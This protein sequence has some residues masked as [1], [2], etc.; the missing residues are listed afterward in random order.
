MNWTTD[1]LS[2][3][4]QYGN[5]Q[6]LEGC[7]I[8]ENTFESLFQDSTHPYATKIYINIFCYKSGTWLF[9]IIIVLYSQHERLQ[10]RCG[11]FWNG[12]TILTL[13]HIGIIQVWK[14]QI[15]ILKKLIGKIILNSILLLVVFLNC[16][17]MHCIC[18]V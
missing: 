3:L 9:Y 2:P 13:L 17:S 6:K 8:F 4:L 7:F 5:L 12:R 10:D 15:N 1:Q 18:I 16:V 11:S 14:L